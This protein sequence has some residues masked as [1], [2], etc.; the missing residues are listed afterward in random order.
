MNKN[1]I[2][3]SDSYK[4]SHFKQYPNDMI[5]MFDYAEAR[6]KGKSTVFVGLQYILKEYFT[7]TITKEMVDEANMYAKIHGIPFNYDGWFYIATFLG[8]KLPIRIRA[9]PEGKNIPNGNVLFTIESTDT[10]VPWVVSWAETMLMRCWYPSNVATISK[11]IKDVLMK[12]AEAS[13]DEPNVDLS[14]HNFGA[15]GSSSEE[16][17]QIG[18]FAHL[19]Q[20]NGTDNFSAIKFVHDYYAGNVKD[21]GAIGISIPASEHSTVT[22]WKKENEFNMVLN[23]LDNEK[24][25]FIIACVADS[26]DYENFVNEVTSDIRFTSKINSDEFPI[27]VIRPDSGDPVEMIE[28]T[29]DIMESNGV[30]FKANN[31]GFRVFN[32]YRI[33]WGDGINIEAITKM[34]N[35]LV[36]RGYSTENIAFGMGGALMQ[37]NES[38]SNNRDTNGWAIKCSNITLAH[39]IS[40]NDDPDN[41]WNQKIIEEREVFKDPITA[42]NKKSKKGKITTYYSEE[43]DLYFVDEIG[44]DFSER[45]SDAVDI[46]EAVFENGEMK[47]EYSM[48]EV[49]QNAR[50]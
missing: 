23:Y 24:G 20:F 17:S 1:I 4:Y 8:G 48:D 13:Q 31:K 18:G 34:L 10:K 32:K 36:S 42:P 3:M 35:L 14:L 49:R 33:I 22:G 41:E 2:M 16:T 30:P 12:Y 9:V 50:N 45:Y 5:G 40:S 28:K 7:K 37:G 29:L 6:T 47:K 44:I 26:Y 19:T 46:L 15:R 43:K 21:F 25:S 38:T 27:F 11:E 39:E